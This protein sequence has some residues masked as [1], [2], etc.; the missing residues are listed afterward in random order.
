MAFRIYGLIF[1]VFLLIGALFVLQYC[2]SGIP[3]NNG[4]KDHSANQTARS[5]EQEKFQ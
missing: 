4:V 5:E 3:R 2:L 1:I